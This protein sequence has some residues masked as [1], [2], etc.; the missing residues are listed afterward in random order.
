LPILFRVLCYSLFYIGTIVF[1]LV[2]SM[3]VL[4]GSRPVPSKGYFLTAGVLS[5]LAL[6][7]LF[8]STRDESPGAL[9]NASGVGIV[10]ELARIFRDCIPAGLD[11][12]FLFTGAE[13]EGLAGAVRF[14]Q[15]MSP[16]YN[17]R[18]TYCVNYDG[19]GAAGK[20]RLTS[21]YG[22]P[23][24][25]TSEELV[26]IIKRYCREHDLAC[27]ETYLPVGAGLEQTP[28]FH[29]GFEAVTIHSGKLDRAVLA[30]H[31]PDDRP[32]NLDVPSMESCGRAGEAVAWTL[33]A[34]GGRT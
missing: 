31:S 3:T 30:I 33:S 1:L 32:E 6:P 22:I 26:D 28:M 14:V 24:V 4:L 19:A 29:R 25:K 18:R 5:L 7:L 13:E 27:H 16:G 12:T 20:I 23:P 11:I 17:G 9:D 10:L 8:N 15:E 34:Q 21:R 2:L